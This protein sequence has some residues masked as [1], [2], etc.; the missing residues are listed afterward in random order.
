MSNWVEDTR[1]YIDKSTIFIVPIRIGGG[2]RLKIYEGM[3]MAKP[4]ISTHIG[5]EGLPLIH[6]EHIYFADTEKE[7][8]EAIIHLL[9]NENE[10]KRR[11]CLR[12]F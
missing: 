6:N 8:A 4:V 5:A 7:F 2:T 10:R 11:L 9:E 12:K 1:P 3:A